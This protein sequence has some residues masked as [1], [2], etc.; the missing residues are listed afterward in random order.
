MGGGVLV[1]RRWMHWV[2]NDVDLKRSPL[3]GDGVKPKRRYT[4]VAVV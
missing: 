3:R 4:Y 2:V 1:S